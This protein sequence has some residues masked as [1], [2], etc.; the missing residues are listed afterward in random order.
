MT[1]DYEV[2]NEGTSQGTV[3]VT[4]TIRDTNEVVDV[5]RMPTES[6]PSFI[7]RNR[8]IIFSEEIRIPDLNLL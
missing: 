3:I 8:G 5:T 2:S 1:R 4:T 6:F 7:N